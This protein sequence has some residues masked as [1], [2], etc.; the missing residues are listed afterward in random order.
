MLITQ[1]KVATNVPKLTVGSQ[2]SVKIER[3]I[4]KTIAMPGYRPALSEEDY[5]QCETAVQGDTMMIIVS[6]SRVELALLEGQMIILGCSHPANRIQP[7]FDL[8]KFAGE[9][10]GTSRMHVAIRR[11]NGE[12]LLEDLASA[13]GTWVNGKRLAPF[14]AHRLKSITQLM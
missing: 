2:S 1:N 12:W 3:D 6:A 13:N 10:S 14:F 9:G 4:E 5:S 8:S 7:T 11:E